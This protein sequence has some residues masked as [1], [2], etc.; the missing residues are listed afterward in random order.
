MN[1]SIKADAWVMAGRCVAVKIAVPQ[2]TGLE[3][4][5]RIRVHPGG[6]EEEKANEPIDLQVDPGDVPHTF[7]F[8]NAK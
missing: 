4:P 8:S 7:P 5:C 6:L 3:T 1:R 2:L